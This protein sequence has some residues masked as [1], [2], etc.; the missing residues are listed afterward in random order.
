VCGEERAVC[1]DGQLGVGQDLQTVLGVLVC[2]GGGSVVL[3]HPRASNVGDTRRAGGV[4]TLDGLCNSVRAG[5]EAEA[6]VGTSTSSLGVWVVDGGK[7]RWMVVL[8]WVRL[9]C[10][11]LCCVVLCCVVLCGVVWCCVVLCCVVLCCVFGSW[12]GWLV[13]C[14]VDVLS[15]CCDGVCSG[16]KRR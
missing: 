13:L 14:C 9:R 4:R 2:A 7:R 1:S 8:C 5:G 3:K 11:V 12:V 16:T 10:V 6:D 15:M